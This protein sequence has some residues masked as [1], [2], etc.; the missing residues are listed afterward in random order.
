MLLPS[1][2]VQLPALRAS[3]PVGN[4]L[5]ANSAPA[6]SVLTSSDA[7]FLTQPVDL[8]R[9]YDRSRPGYLYAR[10]SAPAGGGGVQVPCVLRTRASI[11]TASAPPVELDAPTTF[12]PPLLWPPAQPELIELLPVA[13]P[14]YFNAGVFPPN[15]AF[16]IHFIRWGTNP[17]DLYGT[18]YMLLSLTL[19]YSALCHECCPC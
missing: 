1:T 3:G 17:L 14:G 15:A 10:I 4:V 8:P 13:G 12:T 16:G 2:E 11:L 5:M 6:Y 19:R 7:G 9:N 18:I